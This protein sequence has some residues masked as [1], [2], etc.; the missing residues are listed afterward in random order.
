MHES[1]YYHFI[2]LLTTITGLFS[3]PPRLH[4]PTPV[5]IIPTINII[6]ITT[7][8]PSDTLTT[9]T[10]I[11]YIN[12]NITII[13]IIITVI[14]LLL[15]VLFS[16]LLYRF[17]F[18]YFCKYCCYFAYRPILEFEKLPTCPKDP[19]T[20]PGPRPNLGGGPTLRPL[21]TRV[22]AMPALRVLVKR[23]F[24]GKRRRF[25]FESKNVALFL[26]KD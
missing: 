2:F 25:G 21:R 15:R 14:T 7:I 16:L 26:M 19:H 11:F 13:T 18:C 6:T 9:N 24:K 4:P 8:I 3:H 17:W 22:P 20:P 23:S 12:T 5:A 1:Y 10:T